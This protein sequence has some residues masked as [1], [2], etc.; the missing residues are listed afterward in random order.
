MTGRR[1]ARNAPTAGRYGAPALDARQPVE[2]RQNQ[3]LQERAPACPRS[4]WQGPQSVGSRS[5]N[6]DV[7]LTEALADTPGHPQSVHRS[8]SK[9]SWSRC[10]RAS[11]WSRRS[12]R[13]AL[14]A[15]SLDPLKPRLAE[16]NV[17]H[18]LPSSW[19]L[20]LDVNEVLNRLVAT[21]GEGDSGCYFPLKFLGDN[22]LSPLVAAALM[23]AGH[24]ALHVRDID[25][26]AAS[27]RSIFAGP[28]E[29]SGSS[30]RRM[31][32]SPRCWRNVRR[33]GHP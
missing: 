12:T 15:P 11:G 2:V 6:P 1:I 18:L 23:D 22:A 31:P 19:C 5:P 33:A 28:R 8:L 17:V 27:D 21:E 10:G 29:K 32:T 25:M 20:A 14:K 16:A 9:D 7:H 13:G 4:T 30:Y 24:E 26:Q 3:A